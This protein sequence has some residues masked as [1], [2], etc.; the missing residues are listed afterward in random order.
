MSA[1]AIQYI[2]ASVFLVLGGSCLIS[3]TSVLELS[4]TPAYRS[5]APIVPILM[6]AFGAQALI[7]GLFAAFSIFMKQHFSPTGWR[8]F[9]SLFST[10]GFT[11]SSRC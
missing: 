10:I 5:D 3:P 8:C 9:P 11:R 7:A 2:L 4:I 6:G 1:R